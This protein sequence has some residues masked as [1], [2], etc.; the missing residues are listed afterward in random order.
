MKPLREAASKR[1][2]RFA[3]GR[4]NLFR[5]RFAATHGTCG[6][7]NGRPVNCSE[8]RPVTK[9]LRCNGFVVGPNSAGSCYVFL[10][11]YYFE[12]P[13]SSVR[14]VKSIHLSALL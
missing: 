6:F 1:E 9:A 10:I 14:L 3:N 5:S 4:G 11:I 13:A 8:M 12:R 2:V 7:A